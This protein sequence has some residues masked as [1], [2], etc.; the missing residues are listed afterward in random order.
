MEEG[1]GLTIYP[2]QASALQR[3]DDQPERWI[4]VRWDLDEANRSRFPAK[5][6]LNTLNEPGTLAAV[7]KTTA[8]LDINIKT[9]HMVG[10]AASD[11]SDIAVEVEVW[12]LRHL[13]QLLSQL[14]DL[15]CVSTVKRVYD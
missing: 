5:L 2:I 1:K 8:D 6:A 7:C 10:N 13:T 3:F 15:D 14:K 4:D 12:D 9:L 11:F